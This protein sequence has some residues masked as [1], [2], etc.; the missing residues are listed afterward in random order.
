MRRRLTRYC[1]SFG[2]ILILASMT[3][4]CGRRGRLYAPPDPDNPF[5][6][7]APGLPPGTKTAPNGQADVV[8]KSGLHKRVPNPAIV[9]PKQPFILDPIL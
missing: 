6:A 4:G 2:V 8:T 7:T 1:A 3:G 9:P 5:A